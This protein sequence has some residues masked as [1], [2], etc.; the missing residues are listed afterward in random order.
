[1]SIYEIFLLLNMFRVLLHSFSGAGDCI[2]VLLCFG[3]YWCGSAGVGWYPSAGWSTAPTCIQ[4]PPYS[5]R[6]APTH[7]YTP[8]Q[9][10]VPTYSRQPLRMNVI[11]L[12]TC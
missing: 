9:S 11:A 7:Q 6:T 8:K 1:M 10:S 5:S 4:I 2:G 12:E 3:V